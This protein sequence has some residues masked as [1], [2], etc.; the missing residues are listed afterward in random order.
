M[1]PAKNQTGVVLNAL[2]VEKLDIRQHIARNLCCLEVNLLWLMIVETKNMILSLCLTCRYIEEEIGGDEEV[3]EGMALMMKKTLLAPEREE[4][5]DWVWSSIFLSSCNI[6][7]RV[8]SLIIDGGSC[9]NVVAQEVVDKLDLKTQ[10]H[11]QPYKLS[12]LKKG[13]AIKVTKE[14]LVCHFQSVRS[15]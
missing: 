7:G 8:C 10:D 13:N 5:K 12:W 4:E 1:H 14:C 11:P 6:G 9:E 2:N 15:L 3:E